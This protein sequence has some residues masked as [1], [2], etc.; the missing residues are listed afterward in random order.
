[1]QN[2]SKIYVVRH[3]QTDANVAGLTHSYT[4]TYGLNE[5]GREQAREVAKSLENVKFDK[6]FSSPLRRARETACI[7]AG[8][9]N[10]II[11]ERITERNFGE[12]EG[13]KLQP[14]E[15]CEFDLKSFFDAST[16]QQY[17]SAETIH[18][19]E[20]RVHAFL[21]DIR[22]RYRGKNILVVTHGA[23]GAH[24][25]TYIFGRPADGKYYKDTR[26]YMKN[27]EVFEIENGKILTG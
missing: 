7:I 27:C 24:Y 12:F 8:T 22:H 4:D 14:F 20:Q 10:I 6:V 19:A 21:D 18:A 1:M 26:L 3:G 15:E 11:D 16:P 25:K 9:D 23:I 2:E 13:L 17:E 5:T